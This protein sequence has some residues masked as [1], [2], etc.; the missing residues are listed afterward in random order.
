MGFFSNGPHRSQRSPFFTTCRSRVVTEVPT[1]VD[2]CNCKLH[3]RIVVGGMKRPHFEVIQGRVGAQARV[4]AGQV[5][6]KFRLG[7]LRF[8]GE[9]GICFFPVLGADF[10]A[11]VLNCCFRR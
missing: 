7:K 11:Q 9:A 6:H 1:T 10:V 5:L 8:V 3:L 4:I 2:Q